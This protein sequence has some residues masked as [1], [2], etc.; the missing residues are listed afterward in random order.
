[1]LQA[2]LYDM[3]LMDLNMPVMTGIDCVKAFSAWEAENAQALKRKHRQFICAL[4]ANS[5]A[6]VKDVCLMVRPQFLHARVVNFAVHS[7]FFSL[8]EFFR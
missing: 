5:T 7:T 8:D 6:E 3:V 1:M 2:E 4:T